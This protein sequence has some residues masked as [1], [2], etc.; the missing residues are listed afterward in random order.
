MGNS[1]HSL[2]KK[3]CCS[4]I[5]AKVLLA[6]Y[7]GSGR[8]TALYRMKLGETVSSTPTVGFNVESLPVEDCILQ[9][10]DL[11]GA[12]RL[13]QLWYHY[14]EGADGFAFFID[15]SWNNFEESAGQLERIVGYKGVRKMPMLIVCNKKDIASVT[16]DE[17]LRGHNMERYHD[18]R[19]K[20]VEA[21]SLTG[22]GLFEGFE[23]LA[24]EIIKER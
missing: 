17:A 15:L 5:K 8:T 4:T 14:F 10:W 19:I 9:V 2:R 21:C 6:G 16:V 11:G 20:V 18:M 24:R 12:C 3:V 22:E 13:R 7:C 1:F 23:W